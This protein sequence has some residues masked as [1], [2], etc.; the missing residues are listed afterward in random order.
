MQDQSHCT[1]TGFPVVGKKR[2]KSIIL[3]KLKKLWEKFEPDLPWERGEYD[4]S[5]T[6]LLDDSPHKALCNPVSINPFF[7]AKNLPP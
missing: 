3:K 4:E 6:L 2:S 1:D 5:N 7:V